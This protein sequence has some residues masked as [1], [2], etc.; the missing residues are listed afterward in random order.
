M[1]QRRNAV[2]Y[3]E[4]SPTGISYQD[5]HF[6]PGMNIKIKKTNQIVK[7]NII[8][9]DFARKKEDVARYLIYDMDNQ[10]LSVDDIDLV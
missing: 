6:F 1:N 9:E 10:I 7:I 8:Y 2:Y 5:K 3:T 4:S